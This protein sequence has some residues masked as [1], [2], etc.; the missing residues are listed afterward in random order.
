M[1]A[2]LDDRKEWAPTE[3]ELTKVKTTLTNQLKSADRKVNDEA[4]RNWSQVANG[5]MNF[6]INNTKIQ[7]ISKITLEDVKRVYQKIVNH[8]YGRLN[9][10]IFTKQDLEADRTNSK[11]LN[12]DHY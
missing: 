8:D 6:R 3:Q 5:E 7:V 4:A 2:Y 10:K 1:N 9:I 11:K 12:A